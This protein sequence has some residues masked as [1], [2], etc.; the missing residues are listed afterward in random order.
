M[1]DVATR[2]WMCFISEKLCRVGCGGGGE[3][4]QQPPP[5]SLHPCRP[6]PK[7][8]HIK[9]EIT[10][11]KMFISVANCICIQSVLWDFYYMFNIDC[12]DIIRDNWGWRSEKLSNAT[13]LS[14]QAFSWWDDIVCKIEIILNKVRQCV[15]ISSNIPFK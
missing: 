12:G 14:R 2:S 4:K 8:I 1:L 3:N 15:I 11:I 10:F 5:L 9:E 6:F 7:H 13:D